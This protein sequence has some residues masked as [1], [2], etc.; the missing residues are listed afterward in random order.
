MELTCCVARPAETTPATL[1][2]CSCQLLLLR[3]CDTV[4]TVQSGQPTADWQTLPS[5]TPYASLAITRHDNS[6]STYINNTYQRF[7]AYT[8]KIRVNFHKLWYLHLHH[9]VRL[10]YHSLENSRTF[11][12]LAL[13][14][15]GLFR[16]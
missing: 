14:F 10:P 16:A 8:D 12:E 6:S 3:S 5:T 4:A 2:L 15:P 9:C 1:A 13:K 7:L 11:Q